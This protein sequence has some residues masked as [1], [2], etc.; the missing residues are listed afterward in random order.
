MFSN[1]PLTHQEKQKLHM[2][3]RNVVLYYE[4]TTNLTFMRHDVIL[5]KELIRVATPAQINHSISTLHQKY[6]QRFTEFMYI[7][8]YVAMFKNK[9][10]GGKPIEPKRFDEK[11]TWVYRPE[12]GR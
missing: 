5:L 10:R 9:R 12:N 11:H 1:R 3:E 4:R 8:P 7:T 2:N 6:P